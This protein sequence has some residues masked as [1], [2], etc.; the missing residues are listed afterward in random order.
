MT[1]PPEL[2]YVT[3]IGKIADPTALVIFKTPVWLLGNPIVHP[4]GIAAV[5]DDEGAFSV[6]LP[7]TDDPAWAPVDWAYAV[8]IHSG[9]Q[10]LYGTLAVPYD[11]V[12]SLSL[13][14]VMQTGPQPAV[15]AL[16]V[17]LSARGAPS[18]VAG[19]NADGNVIDADGDVVS[20]TGLVRDSTFSAKGSLLVAQGASTPADLP[21]GSDG[22]TLTADSAAMAGVRWVPRSHALEAGGEAIMD[23]DLG[24]GGVGIEVGSMHIS[25]FTATRS[26]EINSIITATVETA[27]AGNTLARLGIY[28]VGDDGALLELLASTANLAGLWGNTYQNVTRAL[29]GPFGKVAGTRYGVGFL[30]VGGT[31]PALVGLFPSASIGR[32]N[33]RVNGIAFAQSDLP[34]ALAANAISEDYRKLQAVLIPQEAS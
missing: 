20:T 8:E 16:Y 10:V 27:G 15:G 24:M 4:F 22:R 19:L 14:A 31:A 21:V 11:T 32:V 23:R 26:E 34:A 1:L 25:Y 13:E 12:G 29:T 28:S 33:P 30:V 9:G 5:L 17:P 18:G 2:T 6:Q 7:A 3:V